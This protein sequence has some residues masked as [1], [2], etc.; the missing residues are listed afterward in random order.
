MGM[1]M[2]PQKHVYVNKPCFWGFFNTKEAILGRELT[3]TE[4]ITIIYVSIGT[5][6]VLGHL[7]NL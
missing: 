3:A 6:K 2:N 5:L 1:N 4:I 7:P